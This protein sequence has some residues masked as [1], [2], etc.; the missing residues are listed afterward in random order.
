MKIIHDRTSRLRSRSTRISV[1]RTPDGA[2]TAEASLDEFEAVHDYREIVE[3]PDAEAETRRGAPAARG[4]PRGG[5]TGSTSVRAA[6][7]P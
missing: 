5:A 6:P 4:L 2:T 7:V 3:Y 1:E